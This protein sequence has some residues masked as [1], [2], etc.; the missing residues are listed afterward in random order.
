VDESFFIIEYVLLPR[1]TATNNT[2]TDLPS[3]TA[4]TPP[5]EA[6]EAEQQQSR[7]RKKPRRWMSLPAEQEPQQRGRF[8]DRKFGTTSNL[9]KRKKVP[10]TT[11]TTESD[12]PPSTNLSDTP[13][14]PPP[15]NITA[16]SILNQDYFDSPEANVLFGRMNHEETTTE[17]EVS[18]RTMIRQRIDKLTEAFSLPDGWKCVLED[19]DSTQTCSSFQ[20]YSIQIR[21]RYL[22]IAL[23]IALKKMG[24]GPGRATWLECCLEAMNTVNEFNNSTYIKFHGTIRKWHLWFRRNGE[25]FPNPNTHKKDGKKTLPRLLEENPDLKDAIVYY[26]QEHLHKLSRKHYLHL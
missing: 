17:D 24:Q 4:S 10:D 1:E 12:A 3:T 26:A 16:L 20:I 6:E 14:P 21:C 5:P 19:R 8:N 9:R 7:P 2:T 25:C 11:E 15:T 13:P 23:R 18:V 22:A